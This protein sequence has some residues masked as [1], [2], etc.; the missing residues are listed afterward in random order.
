V[1]QY[2]LSEGAPTP[3]GVRTEDD[4]VNVAVFSAH[5]NAVFFCIFDEH[6]TEVARLPLPARTGDVFHGRIG[7]VAPGVHYGLRAAGPWDPAHGHRFNPTKLLVDPFA[8]AIDRPFRLHASLFDGEALNASDSAPFM[9][10]AIVEAS[11]VVAAAQPRRFDWNRQVIY[12]LHVRGFTMRHP[13]IPAEQRG[14]FAALAHPAAI[15]HLCRL[16]VS[17]VELMPTAA[18]IDERHLPALGL[19]N[20][21][22]YNPIALLAPDPRLAPGGWPEV[23]AAIGALHEAG[24]AVLL[25]IVLN[26]TGEG[27]YLGPTLSLRGLDNA[28]CYR[29]LA[30]DRSRYVSDTGCGN[31]LALDH[32]F[33]VRLAMEALRTWAMRG[34]VDGFRLDLATTLGRRADGF[35]PG[36]PLFSA[37]AQD[38]V[39]SGRVIIAEPWDV[40]PGGYQFGAFP[41]AWGEWNG[42]YRDTVRRF[43]R[44]DRGTLGEMA[45][46]FAGSADVFAT[47]NRPLTRSINFVTAHDG[48]TLA[49]LVAHA[50]KHN[51]ANGE[52]N[53]DGTDE[54]F[55]W[56][57]G[58]EGLTGDPTVRA[59]RAR[60]VRALLATLLLSRGTPMLSMGDER[61]RTQGGNNNA[62]TQDNALSWLDWESLDLALEQF[63]ARLLRARLGCPALI[64]GQPL[65]GRPVDATGTPDVA[66]HLPD[67]RTPS[68]EDWQR[69]DNRTLIAA[70]YAAGSRAAV[71]M[72]ADTNSIEIVLPAPRVGRRWRC[73]IDSAAPQRDEPAGDPFPVG[74]RSVVLLVEEPGEGPRRR[75]ALDELSRAAGIA[76][77]WWDVS[78]R[79]HRVRDDTRRALLAAMQLPAATPGDIADSL[80]RL[81]ANALAA[82]PRA[83]VFRAGQTA[84]IP[85]GPALCSG[86]LTLVLENGETARFASPPEAP[87]NITLPPLP[88]GRHRLFLN[89]RPEVACHLAIVPARCYLPLEFLA[90]QR[91]FG[92]AAQLYSLRRLRDQGIG[93]FTTLARLA[94]QAAARG[95]AVIGLNPLHALYPTDRRRV[96]PYQPSHREF[97]DPI[98]I[99]VDGLP[100]DD[101]PGVDY[102]RVWAAKRRA[103]KA[104]FAACPADDPAFTAFV[105]TGGDALRHFATFEAIADVQQST[106]WQR[107]P[108]PLQHPNS[109]AVARF[110]VKHANEIR[111]HSFLQFLA[112]K[113]LASASEVA[114]QAGLRLGFYRDLAVG[115]APDG[116]EAWCRQ[117]A[118]MQGVSVG[119]PPDLF[120]AQGQIW[121]LPP[122]DPFAMAREGYAG[123]ASL[124]AANMRHAGALRIDHVM[125]IERLFVVPDGASARDGAYVSY[126]R[127]DLLGHLAL[128]SE[129]A[130][131]VV[132]GEDLGTVPPGLHEVLADANA[133]SYRVLWFERDGT[134][135]RPPAR[136][137]ALAAACVSTHD[138]PT[139]AGWWSGADI[140][141]R[142]AL[143]ILDAAAAKAALTQRAADKAKLI[144]LLRKEKL[145]DIVA[146]SGP[147]T[148]ALAAAVH[149]LI[150]ATPALLALVQADDLAGETLAINLP[151]TV[152]ERANWSRRLRGDIASLFDG[153]IGAAVVAAVLAAGRATP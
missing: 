73:I 117:D 37:I 121:S 9:P 152:H 18:W 87:R 120:S 27:D 77:T 11:D 125:A 151:G 123:F 46:R 83:L 74:P 115:T 91:H 80:A 119:A 137:P 128:E 21:W 147:M 138:L 48:F 113:Q 78:A 94:E 6:D 149:R 92:I 62:Y 38:P 58:I 20:Y 52:G 143:G 79:E 26:H 68:P 7:G 81:A 35:D 146:L 25:D 96:S 2:A 104:A 85:L 17:A 71:V 32:P 14:T 144:A 4:G 3:L 47:R 124:L 135:F 30:G 16:G 82:L 67:G 141:E 13:A 132:V 122:P 129:R 10:K 153:K 69:P 61:G 34:G 95:A 75:D 5:A 22:G 99:D 42:R 130:K 41:A 116:A 127:Q 64:G 66:W 139:L 142:H 36:A 44:S 93:D 88:L 150:A 43:W 50:G 108:E 39:L 54:N 59:A 84:T 45:T 63:T 106:H 76:P 112:D 101:S 134:G 140:S 70:L 19:N 118:L 49:D 110:A 40:G 107:W 105:T 90:R 8:T 114:R 102:P 133:L 65:T 56:N 24:I 126:P 29:L 100:G 89:A 53:R 15:A 51:E 148:P 1:T 31:T 72:H 136:W 86:W 57:N 131:C 23:A 103:L 111:F 145:L 60:D 97:L 55:S 109:A 33:L 98:Y 28:S 12:E